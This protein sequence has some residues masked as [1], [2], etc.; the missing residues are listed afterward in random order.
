MMQWHG[1]K[2]T[3]DYKIISV[4]EGCRKIR[5]SYV[6]LLTKTTTVMMAMTV[7]HNH[8]HTRITSLAF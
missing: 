7:Q 3:F 5:K 2:Y 8:I 1:L 4:R 6:L